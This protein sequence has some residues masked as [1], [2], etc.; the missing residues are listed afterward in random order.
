MIK[1]E[2]LKK[3]ASN[4]GDLSLFGAFRADQIVEFRLVT[5]ERLDSAELVIHA[6][7]LNREKTEWLTYPMQTGNDAFTLT[8]ALNWLL[9]DSGLTD[10]GLFYYHYDVTAEDGTHVILGGE[11]PTE[12][13]VLENY[14]GERQLLVYRS[15][16]QTSEAFAEGMAYQIFVDRFCRSG[17]SPVKAGAVLDPD[18]ENGVPE[19]GA[20][21]G[22]PVD[23]RT[24]FGGDLPG[25][26]SKL[27]Y[28]A[29]L[30][31]KTL[32][33]T[34][35]FDAA[36]N[37]KYDTGD[38][39]AVDEMFGGDEAFAELCRAAKKRAEQREIPAV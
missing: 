18:W 4:G 6:D 8:L 19:Y 36:S 25:I 33:L 38:Y 22:A 12:L 28:L 13:D 17:R 39:L 3:D 2:E 15:D 16:Y 37:H 27:D 34:P 9:G 29:S 31:V 14:V 5:G 21:P 10:E 1:F 24:F 30:G 32:Y 7:G 20:Y 23:N 11:R 26:T 35:I